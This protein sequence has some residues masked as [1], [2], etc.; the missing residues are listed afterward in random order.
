M[1]LC[2]KVHILLLQGKYTGV[3][4]HR[5]VNSIASSEKLLIKQVIVSLNIN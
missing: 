2:I 1:F 3:V 5:L 4:V